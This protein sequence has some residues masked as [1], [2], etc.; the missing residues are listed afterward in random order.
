MYLEE[1]AYNYEAFKKTELTTDA[2]SNEIEALFNSKSSDIHGCSSM[3]H[4]QYAI[5]A[6]KGLSEIQLKVVDVLIETSGWDKT[7]TIV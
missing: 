3:G 4:D 1:K 7:I 2:I 6:R 5:I